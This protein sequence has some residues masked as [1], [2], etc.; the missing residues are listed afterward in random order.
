ME[1]SINQSENVENACRDKCCIKCRYFEERT[2]FCRYNPPIP[3]VMQQKNG[4]P[5]VTS[6]YSKINMPMIDWC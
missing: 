3:V 6:A 5:F 2:G 4:Q 1:N